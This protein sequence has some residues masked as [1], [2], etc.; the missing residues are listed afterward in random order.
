MTKSTLTANITPPS[1][2]LLGRHNASGDRS[3]ALVVINTLA[4]GNN[5]L[6]GHE[7]HNQEIDEEHD[8]VFMCDE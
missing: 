7:E 1:H 4:L 5:S 6:E 3:S 2:F 8:G